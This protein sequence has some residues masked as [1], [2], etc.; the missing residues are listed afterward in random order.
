MRLTSLSFA[1]LLIGLI[2]LLAGHPLS[3]DNS[4]G[5]VAFEEIACWGQKGEEPGTTCGYLDVPEN[6][7]D[8]GERRIRL[9]IGIFAAEKKAEKKKDGAPPVI[10]LVGG[11]GGSTGIDQTGTRDRWRRFAHRAFAGH[12]LITFDQRGAP[13]S[14]PTLHCPGMRSLRNWADVSEDPTHFD[15]PQAREKATYT[16]C[17]QQLLAQGHD[18][19]AYNSRQSATDLANLVE[20]LGYEKAILVGVSYG[21]YLAQTAMTLFPERFAAAILDSVL[22]GPDRQR[23][24]FEQSL[25]VFRRLIAA[26]QTHER[27]GPAYPDLENDFVAVLERLEAE[28]LILQVW[29]P[30]SATVPLY[31]RVDRNTFLYILYDALYRNQQIT[32]IPW[33]INGLAKGRAERLKPYVENFLTHPFLGLS[34]LGMSASIW[35]Q[36]FYQS[37]PR[38]PHHQS[39]RLAD[40]IHEWSE[41]MRANDVC[42]YWPTGQLSQSEIGA[43][44]GADSE[45]LAS[46]IPVL[47]L[48]GAF[49]PTTPVEYAQ[50]LEGQ[51]PNSFH[52]I[53]PA[54]GHAQVYS[55][56]CAFEVQV[57]FIADPRLRP[58]PDCLNRLRQPAFLA[59]GGE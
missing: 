26:C 57:A 45:T 46:D 25:P 49:D 8:P 32:R 4:Q 12:D 42:S 18:L 3:A 43:K 29:N 19:A 11:P 56:P 38:P 30:D 2:L 53:F 10:F 9:P 21:T 54:T 51:F 23:D 50:N 44:I 17:F 47:L 41:F 35:C 22:T 37:T 48:S 34:A 7:E 14:Q 16:H 24:H 58:A 33:I 20:A 13:L 39:D 55:D 5:Q 15:D 36:D 6:W 1:S 40:Q 28:P 27:C 52:F 59:L 31:A